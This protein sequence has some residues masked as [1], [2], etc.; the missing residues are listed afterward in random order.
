MERLKVL[1]V[2]LTVDGTDVGETYSGFRLIEALGRHA[3]VTLLCLDRPGRKP[4]AEQLPD[5]RV[6][7][8][9]APAFFGRGILP[10]KRSETFWVKDLPAGIV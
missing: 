2:G 3:D 8:F 6:V 7:A 10:V 1:V 5:V 4:T 9:P